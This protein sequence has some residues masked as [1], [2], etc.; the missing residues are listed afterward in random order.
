MSVLG[1]GNVGIGT[2][3]PNTLLTL[4]GNGSN[5]SIL[6]LATFDSGSQNASV[7]GSGNTLAFRGSNDS[8]YFGAVGGYSNGNP[9][10]GLWADTNSGSPQVYISSS[11]NVGIG[12]T[13]P[14]SLLHLYSSTA[15]VAETIQS[16][17]GSVS[18]AM[19]PASN[20]SYSYI[21]LGDGATYGWQVGKDIN[22]GSTGGANGFYIYELDTGQQ[23]TRFAIN[24]G[25]NVGIGTTN[26][27]A[28]LDVNGKAVINGVSE[29][30]AA[31]LSDYYNGNS[32]WGI[33][34]DDTAAANSSAFLYMES[35]GT[36]IGDITNVNNTGISYNTS[37]DIRLKENI[38]TTT[39]GLATLMQI[40]VVD[41]NFISDPT[42]TRV[43]GFIAQW[44]YPIYPEAVTTNGTPAT[45]PLGTSTPWAV[46]YGRLTP[47]LV[48]AIQDIANISSR[49]EQNLIAWLG[50]AKN[51]IGEFFA[52]V[53]NFQTTNT[54]TSNASTTN[55]QTLCITNGSN[56]PSPLC[57][58][59]S[60]LAALLSQTAS[61]QTSKSVSS[62]ALQ[63]PTPE[64]PESV[65]STTPPVIQI[66]GDNPAIV[67]V[68]DTYNDLGATI[69][70]PQ[71][72]LNLGIQTFVNGVA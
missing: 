2:T 66:N 9:G 59:K 70:G 68:G 69:T 24:K 63:N 17:S 21:N 38:A 29:A 4:S 5:G 6:Q 7:S 67:Q 10:L 11:G 19:Q 50:N 72:D 40:P 58:T 16:T 64:I 30:S 60:Q 41:F 48:T 37:S 28:P 47:L 35:N 56:D 46:D 1:N 39:A 32:A 18:L 42:Q 23:A 45:G 20:N 61:A 31:V 62:S 53:G 57:I 71:A 26:P 36:E 12:T 65:S 27:G 52:Q 44:L 43:Q 25:G 34:V 49:F 51:G 8:A 13:S 55:T 3:T 22:S 54:E 14:Q 33:G 15:N